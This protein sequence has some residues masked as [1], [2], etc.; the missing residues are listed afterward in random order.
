[1]DKTTYKALCRTT[2]ANFAPTMRNQHHKRNT[3]Q[4]TSVIMDNTHNRREYHN[5]VCHLND[6]YHVLAN[7]EI[8][9]V[10][11]YW[12]TIPENSGQHTYVCDTLHEALRLALKFKRLKQTV[13]IESAVHRERQLVYFANESRWQLCHANYF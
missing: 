7:R 12:V 2:R 11:A 10:A 8:S 9:W 13:I 5:L 6:Y 1:M 4:I 3:T